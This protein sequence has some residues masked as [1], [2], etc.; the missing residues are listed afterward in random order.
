[1][2][3]VV[4][5]FMIRLSFRAASVYIYMIFTLGPTVWKNHFLLRGAWGSVSSIDQG[6]ESKS[7]SYIITDIYKRIGLLNLGNS[8]KG[9][10]SGVAVKKLKFSYHSSDT[11]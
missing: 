5:G 3:E 11:T 7:P 8:L 2:A 10:F 9:S 1:M 6:I 4:L